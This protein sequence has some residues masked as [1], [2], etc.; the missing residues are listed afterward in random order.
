MARRLGRIGAVLVWLTAGC[1]PTTSASDAGGTDASVTVGELPAEC[2]LLDLAP[3]GCLLPWP[4]S[5]FQTH[6]ASGASPI[7]IPAAAMPQSLD[8]TGAPGPRVAPDPWNARDGFSPMTSMIVRVD[9]S[10]VPTELRSWRDPET[11]SSGATVLLDTTDPST[12][13]PIAHFAEVQHTTELPGTSLDPVAADLATLYVRP[14]ARLEESHH[15]VVALRRLDGARPRS[16]A[17]FAAL[18]DAVATDSAAV[19]ARRATFEQDVLAPLGR[20]SVPRSTLIVAWD[21]W[22]GS[23]AADDLVAMRDAALAM[24][25]SLDCTIDTVTPDA[26]EP[27]LIEV[28]GTFDVP[29]F[30]DATGTSGDALTSVDPG[31]EAR[32]ARDASGRP[33]VRGTRRSEFVAIVPASVVGHTGARLAEYGHGLL[34]DRT[35]LARPGVV[36]PV[37]TATGTIG[38]ATDAY[39]LAT[40]DQGAIAMALGELSRFSSVADRTLQGVIA[41]VVLP[42]VFGACAAR[43]A[44]HPELSGTTIDPDHFVWLGNSQGGIMGPTIAALEPRF[45]RLGLG[46]G[47][48]SYPIMLPRS[49]DWPLTGLGDLLRAAYPDRITRDL[50]MVMF[51]SHWD[52]FEGATFAPHLADLDPASPF[53]RDAPARVLYQIAVNDLGTPEVSGEIAARTMGLSRLD[54]SASSPF[55]IPVTTESAPTSGFVSFDYGTDGVGLVAAPLGPETASLD[56]CAVDADGTHPCAIAHELVR[57]DPFAQQQLA[58]FLTTGTITDVCTTPDCRAPIAAWCRP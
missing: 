12:P 23:D 41:Q 15:Y 51:A 37:L 13:R 8:V 20:A 54:G 25:A 52:R 14:A 45:D 19:E 16:T 22:T 55:G 2:E 6:L 32:I 21:F 26:P 36:G 1:G 56:V 35:E 53:H 43:F 9:P 30:L 49:C 31:G 18:R 10:D 29:Y 42:R 7:A 28:K 39:G 40:T 46:V 57:R 11:G 34:T 4:S 50:L 33:E 24:I 58:G 48:I 27:A 47:G 5:R 44:D 38:L 3:G 17:T